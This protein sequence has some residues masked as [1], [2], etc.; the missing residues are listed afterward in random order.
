MVGTVVDE[1]AW[2]LENLGSEGFQRFRR[3]L[4]DFPQIQQPY[5][6]I[7]RNR[8]EKADERGVAELIKKHYGKDYGVQVALMV[9]EEIQE[10]DAAERL[11]EALKQVTEL[12]MPPEGANQQPQPAGGTDHREAFLDRH[13]AAL[14]SRMSLVSPVLDDLLSEGL[15]NQEKYETVRSVRPAQEQMRTLYSYSSSWSNEDKEKVY[16]ILKKHDG[17]LIADLEG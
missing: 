16:R 12:Q 2:C 5:R 10:M 6:V 15:I 9:L 7:P 13:R 14:I 17:P 4:N 3:K 11:R 1:L 8:L